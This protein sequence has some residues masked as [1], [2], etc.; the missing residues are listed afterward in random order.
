MIK[1]IKKKNNYILQ[2]IASI[3]LALLVI[4][5]S[6]YVV[7]SFRVFDTE[8]NGY[9]GQTY[10]SK[11]E[12]R[13]PVY[14]YEEDI[15]I[16]ILTIVNTFEFLK[17]GDYEGAH[18]YIK[19]SEDWVKFSEK[20]SNLGVVCYGDRDAEGKLNGQ[21]YECIYNVE[22][23][24]YIFYYGDF[25]DDVRQGQG[26]M[27]WLEPLGWH[28]LIGEGYSEY[29]GGWDEGY[30]QGEGVYCTRSYEKLF[31]EYPGVNST[32][33]DVVYSSN[34]EKGLFNG[35]V[36][37]TTKFVSVSNGGKVSYEKHSH[38]GTCVNGVFKSVGD[39]QRIGGK[40]YIAEYEDVCGG[41]CQL[42]GWY[43]YEPADDNHNRGSDKINM[44][45][46]VEDTYKNHEEIEK[47]LEGVEGIEDIERIITEN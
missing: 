24:L 12:Y 18:N 31:Q 33:C 8:I 26:T 34:F 43:W 6:L 9:I 11:L 46:F 47:Y 38:R 29:S 22:W 40:K 7:Y 1:N 2:T 3:I 5:A 32:A 23:D 39:S 20:A 17:N 44:A 28:E 14:D 42:N 30:P 35:K 25:V 37:R 21:G 36:N 27:V 15:D 45:I 4:G 41:G 19:N 16:N 10:I 13:E